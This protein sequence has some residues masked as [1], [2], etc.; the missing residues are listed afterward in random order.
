MPNKEKTNAQ[1]MR[2]ILELDD[3]LIAEKGRG[4]LS[5]KTREILSISKNPA[6]D[7]DRVNYEFNRKLKEA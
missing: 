5:T 2:D 6:Y 3:K 7:D 4:R 1:V